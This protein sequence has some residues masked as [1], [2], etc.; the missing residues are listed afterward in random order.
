MYRA[1][2][3]NRTEEVPAFGRFLC[4]MH[5]VLARNMCRGRE[6]WGRGALKQ[7]T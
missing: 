2:L 6:S 7:V 1:V 5:G 4:E 3:V